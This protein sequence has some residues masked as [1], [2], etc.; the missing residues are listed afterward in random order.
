MVLCYSSRRKLLQKHSWDSG[1]PGYQTSTLCSLEL[2][3]PGKPRAPWVGGDQALQTWRAGSG[4]GS[5]LGRWAGLAGCCLLPA[6]GGH[7]L[8]Q[9]LPQLGTGP[10][11]SGTRRAQT[12]SCWAHE[13]IV[14]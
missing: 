8:G 4:P 3:P 1:M 7:G 9:H 11:P 2:R 5:L 14:V 10:V 6:V 12:R 13:S